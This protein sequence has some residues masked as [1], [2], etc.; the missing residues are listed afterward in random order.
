[1]TREE[2]RQIREKRKAMELVIKTDTKLFG[3]KTAMGF[4]YKF[5]DDFAF[6]IL[7]TTHTNIDVMIRTKPII[8][9]K[10]FW[11]V[12]KM[13]DEVKN[14]PKSFHITGAFVASAV[15]INKFEHQYNTPEEAKDKFK[16]ILEQADSIIENFRKTVFD[17]KTFQEYIK[18]NPYEYLNDI[19]IDILNEKYNE[20][21]NKINQCIKEHKS[22]GF[23]GEKGKSIIEYAK[24]YCEQKL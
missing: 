16:Y 17:I 4:A 5:I 1:M 13:D 21:L 18:N 10:V 6:E 11:E 22:G 19:L 9:D 7:I 24:E 14:M 15:I 3:Y 8:L 23:A 20:A 2:Q 12:F